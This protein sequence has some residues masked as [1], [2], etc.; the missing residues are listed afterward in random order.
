MPSVSW[1][2]QDED[3]GKGQVMSGIS[4]KSNLM[5]GSAA[6]EGWEAALFQ[7]SLPRRAWRVHLVVADFCRLR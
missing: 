4:L 2:A 7:A 5:G 1:A 6:R 3:W